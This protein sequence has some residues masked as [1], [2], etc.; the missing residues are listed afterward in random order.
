MSEN[1]EKSLPFSG[2]ENAAE[3]LNSI[4]LQLRHWDDGKGVGFEVDSCYFPLYGTGWKHSTLVNA[5][6]DLSKG[7]YLAICL[8]PIGL[9]FINSKGYF[10]AFE[11]DKKPIQIGQ[12][13]VLYV[14]N[15]WK[16]K[17]PFMN[18]GYF[19]KL[20]AFTW[21]EICQY[22]DTI[23]RNLVAVSESEI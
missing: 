19:N 18:N 4:N 14:D 22:H 17:F 6:D 8:G 20:R 2:K 5:I 23:P 21:D 11:N 16:F 1:S 12:G 15:I 7:N 10:V 13:Q 9:A 3:F